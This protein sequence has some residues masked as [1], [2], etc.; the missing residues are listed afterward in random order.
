MHEWLCLPA[1][2]DAQ[3]SSVAADVL[4]PLTTLVRFCHSPSM[5]DRA[6]VSVHVSHNSTLLL[7]AVSLE[8]ALS[9]ALHVSGSSLGNITV[10]DGSA[11]L[12]GSAGGSGGGSGSPSPSATAP[13]TTPSSGSTPSAAPSSSVSPSRSAAL[14]VVQGG[15]VTFTLTTTGLSSEAMQALLL[16]AVNLSLVTTPVVARQPGSRGLCCAVLAV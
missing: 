13:S 2:V 8:D 11:P 14:A 3:Q 15:M 16:Q 10:A 4:P 7:P 9:A 5:C 12:A 6:V 1:E